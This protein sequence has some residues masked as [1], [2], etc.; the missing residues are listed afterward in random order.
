MAIR[1]VYRVNVIVCVLVQFKGWVVKDLI[2]CQPAI[3]RKMSR[4][5][6]SA[7]LTQFRRDVAA[8]HLAML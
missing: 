2:R 8:P 1:L 4:V 3:S 7:Q 5:C 6:H